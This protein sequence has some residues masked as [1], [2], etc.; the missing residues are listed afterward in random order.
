VS[1]AGKLLHSPWPKPYKQENF[2]ESILVSAEETS[3]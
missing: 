3:D 1:A 2:E